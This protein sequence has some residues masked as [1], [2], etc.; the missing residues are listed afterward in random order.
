MISKEEGPNIAS[1]SYATPICFAAGTM[2]ST[3]QGEVLIEKI[4]AEDMVRTIEGGAEPVRGIGQRS[5]RALGRFAPIE[6]A[7]GAIGNSRVLRVP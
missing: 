6:F 1:S 7:S 5:Y 3:D 2:I 4:S